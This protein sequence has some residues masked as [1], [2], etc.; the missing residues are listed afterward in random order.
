MANNERRYWQ[1]LE[2][3]DRRESIASAIGLRVHHKFDGAPVR[4]MAGNVVVRAILDI[5]EPKVLIGLKPVAVKRRR[6]QDSTH[7]WL[8]GWMRIWC[9]A[10]Y[11][12]HDELLSELVT[13]GILPATMPKGVIAHD[14]DNER[15]L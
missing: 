7:A 15:Q 14:L 4:R 2:N 10:A 3:K 1:R 12:D 6:E 13:A 8:S 5:L 9:E 11:I